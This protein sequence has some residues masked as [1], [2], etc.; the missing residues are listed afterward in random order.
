MK[1][2][3]RKGGLARENSP[4]PPPSPI[5]PTYDR[6]ADD[7]MF[8]PSHHFTSFFPYSEQENIPRFHILPFINSFGAKIA[9]RRGPPRGTGPE[10]INARAGFACKRAASLKGPRWTGPEKRAGPQ[11]IHTLRI[12]RS[13]YQPFCRHPF[14]PLPQS[15][16]P[17]IYILLTNKNKWKR[18]ER[19]RHYKKLM[20]EFFMLLL[21]F[22]GWRVL[23]ILGE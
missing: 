2:C 14:P 21:V 10:S 11:G 17:W 16:Q 13:Q 15:Q 20:R 22:F 23:C 8:S 19:K 3:R 4:L 7:N 6:P 9:L 5:S 1:I 18:Q 12:C